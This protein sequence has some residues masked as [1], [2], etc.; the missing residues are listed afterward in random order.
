MLSK[1]PAPPPQP[2]N[3]KREAETLR[4]AL[5]RGVKQDLADAKRAKWMINVKRE[6]IKQ[7]ESDREIMHSY[8]QQA[9]L[10]AKTKQMQKMTNE[11]APS[12]ETPQQVEEAMKDKAKAAAKEDTALEEAEMAPAPDQ[13]W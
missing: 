10:K 5:M 1:F 9:L 7:E 8:I 6:K 11:K 3:A 13:D 2:Q 12:A 4:W